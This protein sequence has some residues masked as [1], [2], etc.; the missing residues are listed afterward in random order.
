[1]SPDT[2]VPES[3]EEQLKRSRKAEVNRRYEKKRKMEES[4]DAGLAEKRR[5]R[6]KKNQRDSRARKRQKAGGSSDM[7]NVAQPE[8]V[9]RSCEEDVGGHMDI[10]C[11]P[12]VMASPQS[13]SVPPRSTDLASH[14]VGSQ[15]PRETETVQWPNGQTTV[16]PTVIRDQKNVLESDA[17]FV[18][19]LATY[20]ISDGSCPLVKHVNAGEMGE[21]ELRDAIAT[22]LRQGQCIVVHGATP[23]GPDVLNTEFLYD[24]YG[25][26]P[27]QRTDIHGESS[28]SI[29]NAS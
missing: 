11:G 19:R 4:V 13:L 6:K 17:S 25:I 22:S 2:L 16:L 24:Y 3:E 21:L 5:E 29:Q 20:P 1:M 10:G 9:D 23:A 8:Q 7:E 28:P 18:R 14:M 15:M 27:L 26:S 12:M